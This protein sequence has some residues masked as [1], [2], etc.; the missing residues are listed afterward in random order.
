M[1][2]FLIRP[3]AECELY[4]I[5]KIK[6]FHEDQWKAI[7]K[8]LAG[9]R[10]LLI[11]KTG[12]GKSIC[13]QFPAAIFPGMTIIFS[14]L[15]ALMR[16]Q[17]KYLKSININAEC[18]NGE[19][20]FFENKEIIK[21]A[22]N[23]KLKILYIAPE[24]QESDEWI[25]ATQK[26]NLSMIVVDEAHCISTWGHDFRP[27]FRRITNLVKMLPLGF[28]VLA[29]TAT[30][31][32]KVEEDVAEQIGNN[33]SVIRG[34]L[35][36]EN[37]RLFVIKVN[38]EDEKMMWI[39]ENINKIKG[40][41]IIYTGRR[42]DTE[43]YAKW[44]NFCNIKTAS[45]SGRLEANSRKDIENALI[46]NEYKCVVSTNALGMGMDKPDIRF[47]IHTQVPQSP[48]H[49]YQEIGRAGRD[50]KI[51]YCILFYNQNEDD[52]LP[53]YFINNS[54]PQSIKYEKVIQT[55]KSGLYKE[56]EMLIKTNIRKQELRIIKQ[57]LIEQRIIREVKIENTKKLE[58]IYNAPI[59]N[60][61][62]HQNIKKLK[63]EEFTRM[64]DYINIT[65]SRMKFLCEYLGDKESIEYKNCDNTT[66]KKVF[67]S[68][69]NA[70]KEKIKIFHDNDFPD[71][72]IDIKHTKLINGIATSF[73]GKTIVGELIHKSKYEDAGDYPEILVKRTIQALNY[74]TNKPNFD[75]II[76]IPSTK[77]GQL[78][79]NFAKRISDETGII[80]CNV[81]YKTRETREQKQLVNSQLKKGNVKDAFAVND[82]NAVKDKNILLI[83]DIF[84]SGNT[85]KEIGKMLTKLDAKTIFPLVIAKTVGGDLN[86]R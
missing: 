28:P 44:L 49:Y 66:L 60:V 12:F 51:A 54:K 5:F 18:I 17:V 80:L 8:I 75:I 84:D 15:I 14:P 81:L 72:I 73:Y 24:R 77:S 58:Y 37:L 39:S 26:M 55:C 27:Q 67:A 45:Y 30:A 41:G 36:R 78:V 13:Y 43:I 86:D 69:S 35:M 50:G 29:T 61:E 32:K 42:D 53:L 65:M 70:M 57:D 82:P 11:E 25:D 47:I 64:K 10:V 31:T 9:E 19:Q 21:K 3:Y 56:S 71:L 59:F 74:K 40:S 38:N 46:D 76:Y 68:F 63:L 79:K 48:I 4:R 1:Q 62:F 33:C 2:N 7:T 6:K 85:I 16:D 23:G 83:D 20:T 34:K 52:K 22:T